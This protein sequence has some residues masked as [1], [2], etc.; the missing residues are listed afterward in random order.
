M[1]RICFKE[2][3]FSV[4]PSA[5]AK[6]AYKTVSNF[7][8][9]KFEKLSKAKLLKLEISTF[10]L[11]FLLCQYQDSIYFKVIESTTDISSEMETMEAELEQNKSLC[12]ESCCRLELM[13]RQNVPQNV[14]KWKFSI[15]KVSSA[16]TTPS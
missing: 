1:Q 4:K 13:K 9:T 2:Q 3:N 6:F 7:N 15:F 16:R 10:G 8:N 14:P 11:F 5:Y 12:L